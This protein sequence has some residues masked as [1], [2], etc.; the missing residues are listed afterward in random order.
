MRLSLLLAGM[1][2]YWFTTPLFALFCPGNFNQIEIGD[3]LRDVVQA[4]GAPT[5]S[6]RYSKTEGSG[7]PQEWVYYRKLQ[8]TDAGTMKTAVAFVDGK[9]IN[10]SVNGLGA[11]STNV[12]GNTS[13]NVGDTQKQVQAACGTPDMTNESLNAPA[14]PTKQIIELTY[15]TPP[16]SAVLVFENGKLVERR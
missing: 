6:K 13:I 9:V 16:T 1:T 12:C 2:I 3:S 5:S 14:G 15:T 7:A 8:P 10:I 4:C 11:G